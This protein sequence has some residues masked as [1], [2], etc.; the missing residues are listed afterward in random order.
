MKRAP[1]ARAP[2]PW[3]ELPG[4]LAL[5]AI[6]AVC[7][8]WAWAIQP[9]GEAIRVPAQIMKL[10]YVTHRFR[11]PSVSIEVAFAEGKHAIVTAR[12]SQAHRCK[13]HDTID[14]LSTPV[15]VGQPQLQLHP[16]ACR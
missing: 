8:V 16:D 6:L 4:V 3:G 11:E 10:T 12:W 1:L 15:N 13:P 5:G 9:A 14:I 7:A 2:F